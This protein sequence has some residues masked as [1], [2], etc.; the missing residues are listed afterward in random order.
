MIKDECKA[1]ISTS[2]P[3]IMAITEL[4]PKSGHSNFNLS[5]PGYKTIQNNPKIHQRGVCILVNSNIPA[6]KDDILS[7]TLFSESV[8]CRIPLTGNDCLLVGVIY[9]S[10]NSDSINNNHMFPSYT[11]L[12]CWCFSPTNYWRL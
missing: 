1:R 5:I 7:S 8:W 12:Q 11:S 6:Y 9:R 4:Y 3:D 2:K 10:P